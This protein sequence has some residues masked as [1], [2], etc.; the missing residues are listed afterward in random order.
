[1]KASLTSILIVLNAVVAGGYLVLAAK[2]WWIE[3]ELVDIPGASGG[4]PMIWFLAS[5]WTF[6]LLV[7]LNGSAAIFQC[8]VYLKRKEWK[9][10]VA[11]LL[12]PVLWSATLMIDFSHH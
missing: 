1:M 6:G 3:P 7:L 8:Y 5:L 4:A 10:G 12:I 2:A 9:F 11:A